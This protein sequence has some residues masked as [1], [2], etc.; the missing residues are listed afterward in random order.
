MAFF[1]NLKISLSIGMFRFLMKLIS[2]LFKISP[3]F[4]KEIYN[5][6]TGFIFNA[7]YQFTTRDD[8][9]NVYVIFENGKMR[10][11]KGKVENPNI[12]ISYKDKETMAKIYNKSPDESLDYLLTNEMSYTG[13]MAYLTKF[14][15][16][17]TRLKGAKI[18]DYEGPENQVIQKFEDID[19]QSRKKLNN[20]PLNRKIDRVQYLDDPYFKSIFFMVISYQ[21]CSFNTNGW[22]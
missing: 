13:N 21:F 9:V 3:N 2:F 8:K 7:K 16:I 18:K 10:S 1:K 17:T 22:F 15:Y 11:G 5:E 6:E 20:E 12:T 19:K 4:R 14:S